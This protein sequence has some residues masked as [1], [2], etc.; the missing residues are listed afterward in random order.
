[1]AQERTCTYVKSKT[2]K[3]GERM[4]SRYHISGTRINRNDRA[5]YIVTYID[6]YSEKQVIFLFKKEYGFACK[7]IKII[8]SRNLPE[9]EGQI[10]IS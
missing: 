1:M 10:Y 9:I 4:K 7:E 2:K 8:G 5:E 3:G 6:A